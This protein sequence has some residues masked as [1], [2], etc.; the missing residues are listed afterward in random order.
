MHVKKIAS[1]FLTVA[2]ILSMLPII[3]SAENTE[4]FKVGVE[5]MTAASTVSDSPII[6]NQGDEITVLISAS[7]NSGLTYL[8]LR[9]DY[10]ET[11][12]EPV[13]DDCF[14]TELFTQTSE[15][16]KQKGDILSKKKD[17]DGDRWFSFFFNSGLTVKKETGIFAVITFIAKE[18]CAVETSITVDLVTPNSCARDEFVDYVNVPMEYDADSFSIHKI[19]KSTGVVTDPNCT[20]EGYTTYTCAACNEAVVGNIVPE[21]GHDWADAVEENRVEATCTKEGSYELATYCKV[22][23]E[24]KPES[25]E[26]KTIPMLPHDWADAVEENR[27]EATC[28][29][30]GSYELA[31]YC[32]DCKVEK[33]NSRENKTIE[34]KPHNWAEAVEEN[35]VEATCTKEGS[36]ELAIYCKDCKVEKEN[37]RVTV[38]ITKLAHNWAEAV[39]ENRVEAT[40]TKEGSYELAI[41][42]KVCKTEKENS[43]ATKT[44]AKLDHNWA[45]A[46]E[47]NRKE[48]TC[49][50]EGSYELAIYC[51]DCKV[52]KEN[53]RVTKTIP[54]LPHTL[55]H[56][57][58][59]EANHTQIGWNEYDTC[60]KCDYTTYVE[61][62]MVP[63]MAGDVTGD[64]KVTDADAVYL[65]YATFYADKYPLNQ[66]A[67][68]NGDGKVTDADAVYLLYA[69]FYPE[70]YPLT[71][72]EVKE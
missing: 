53:S 35:R 49:A 38:P 37:S 30:E 23:E 40:C 7:Q 69:T 58:A 11:V 9:I 46:V 12:L 32:K 33:E 42:C 36:Y 66:A 5:A 59:Q 62:P 20:D 52:E 6:Y 70:K 17:A 41:Y 67:D 50:K 45:E 43:R 14:A 4:I 19:D 39:E 44:I 51:K 54:A 47:E 13:D 10:D 3:G 60:E 26:Y 57:K 24:E 27:K 63:Y 2:L 48:A 1:I 25:R 68:Y 18:T 65:L 61:I 8:Q 15:D 22:C 16:G 55:V 72:T 64:D 71:K 29:K 21:K 31:I 56:H 34:M 28:T